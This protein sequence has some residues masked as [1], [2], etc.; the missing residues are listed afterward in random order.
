[1]SLP[2]GVEVGALPEE[3]VG[4]EGWAFAVLARGVPFP[5]QL[6]FGFL[7]H[8]PPGLDNFECFDLLWVEF[9]RSSSG[10]LKVYL[11]HVVLGPGV[12][13]VIVDRLGTLCTG[14]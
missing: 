10:S 3:V 12:F 5:S 1:M 4:G 8:S 2:Y 13:L 9:G 7:V 14:Y 6:S 11:V